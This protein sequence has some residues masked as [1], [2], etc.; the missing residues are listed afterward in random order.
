VAVV[1]IVLLVDVAL[2]LDVRRNEWIELASMI[3]IAVSTRKKA[4]AQLVDVTHALN[5]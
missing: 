2:T 4:L 1:G 3:V 5:A